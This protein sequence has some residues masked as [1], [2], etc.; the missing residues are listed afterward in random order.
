MHF[1]KKHLCNY[2]LGKKYQKNEKNTFAFLQISHFCI[3][4]DLILMQNEQ[5][6]VS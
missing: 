2:F 4:C 3:I 1:P 5:F 6:L